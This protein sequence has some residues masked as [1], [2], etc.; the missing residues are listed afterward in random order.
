MAVPPKASVTNN[1]P[2]KAFNP[3]FFISHLRSKKLIGLSR[4]EP[5]ATRLFILPEA[6]K[7][8]LQGHPPRR[9]FSLHSVLLVLTRDAKPAPGEGV[10]EGIAT[11]RELV[12]SKALPPESPDSQALGITL[13]KGTRTGLKEKVQYFPPRRSTS[14]PQMA[15]ALKRPLPG[16]AR[17]ALLP[18]LNLY[19]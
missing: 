10:S 19:P 11:G 14:N 5:F 3:H 2:I 12:P 9:R 4:S 6:A 1:T 13:D 18:T 16:E 17:R 15:A 7:S 8:Q